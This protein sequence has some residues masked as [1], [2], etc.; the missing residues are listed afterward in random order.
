MRIVSHAWLHAHHRTCL[1][2]GAIGTG[3]M[4]HARR[5]SGLSLIWSWTAHAWMRMLHALG[6][7]AA[8]VWIA[9]GHH[10]AD[11]SVRAVAS[12]SRR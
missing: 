7:H 2:D 12:Q 8:V 3:N 6:V 5:H 4:L 9:R 10:L 11:S 1:A